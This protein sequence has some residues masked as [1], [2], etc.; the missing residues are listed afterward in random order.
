MELRVLRYFLM[1]AREENITRAANLLHVTQPTLS[2]QLMQLEEELDTK[3][4]LRSNHNIILTED[5][6]LLK[7]RA[8]EILSLVERTERDFLREEGQLTGKITI[9]SGDLRSTEFLADLIAAFHRAHPLVRYE[10]YSGNAD[11]I[12][13]RIERG[14]LDI[15]LLVEP[16]DI[17]RYEF[18]RSPLKEEYGILVPLDS[19]L[20]Q[21]D[22][23]TLA[24]LAGQSLIAANRE[25]VQNEFAHWYGPG[26]E[27]LDILITG[28]LPYNMAMMARAGLGLSLGV[29]LNEDY[30]GL[31][32]VPLSPKLESGSVLAWKK[33]QTLSPAVSAFLDAAKEYIKGIPEHKM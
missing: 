14:L 1:V 27:S 24:D 2:R 19:P 25:L 21:R 12:K 22:S 10:L 33:A 15:G 7:R 17:R 4:F 31:R 11:N 26:A 23:I 6:M 13:E 3:L 16:V 29:H 28:N 32:F 20:A 18:L 5:G 8:Q 9:G 30:H